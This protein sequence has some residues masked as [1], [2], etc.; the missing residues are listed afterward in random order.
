MIERSAPH[1]APVLPEGVTAEIA[2]AL[3]TER[4]GGGIYT[5]AAP[6]RLFGPNRL[7]VIGLGDP[8][9]W[10][11]ESKRLWANAVKDIVGVGEGT[12]RAA[13]P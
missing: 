1:G 7:I 2:D 6:E 3:L 9:D 10:N 4:F 12:V 8:R 13:R 5:M 11:T